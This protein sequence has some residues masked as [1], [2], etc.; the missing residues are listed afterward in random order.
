[1]NFQINP[2]ALEQFLPLFQLDDR[3][4]TKH[5]ACR[6]MVDANPGFPCRVSLEDAEIGERVILLTYTH[7]RT[8]SPYHAA[9][10]IFVREGAVEA[11]LPPAQVPEIVRRR[12]MSVRAYDPAGM[13]KNARVVE[14][15]EIETCID[16]FFADKSIEYLHLHNAGAGCYSCRVDRA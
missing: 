14:G 16:E 4:L 13:M 3:E 5:R 9:G 1:M 6:M 10:P 12:A 2:L 11:K 15:R 8:Q 7:Q